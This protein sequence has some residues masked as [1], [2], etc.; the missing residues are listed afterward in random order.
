MTSRCEYR[1]L[2]RQDNAD[3]RLI[4]HG[5]RAGLID[6]ARYAER[7]AVFAAIDAETE[8]AESTYLSPSPELNEILAERGST[9][10]DTGISV[11]EL[12]RRPELTHRDLAPVDVTR[13]DLSAEVLDRAQIELKYAGYIKRQ[14][15]EAEAFKKLESRLIPPGV[16]YK[17]IRGLRLEAAGKL[18]E[19]RPESIGEASRISGGAPADI[20]VLLIALGMV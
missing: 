12:L 7:Q 1:L 14:K 20:T 10:V 11:A 16:D 9:P 4:E 8:R 3:R 17:K 15:A 18:D 5:R 13:P 2:L 19:F 6:D